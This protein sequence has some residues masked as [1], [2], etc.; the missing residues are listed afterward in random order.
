[1]NPPTSNPLREQAFIPAIAV[2]GD[3]SII[4]TYYDFENDVSTP[5]VELADYYAVFCRPRG[6]IAVDCSKSSNWSDELRLT[7][8]SFNFADAPFAA[9]LFLG[10]YMGLVASG[11]QVYPVFGIVTNRLRTADFTRVITLLLP[12]ASAQ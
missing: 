12:V 8:T 4:V 2:A 10:D 3:G 1:M 6:I 9:G 7:P 11:V 5:G